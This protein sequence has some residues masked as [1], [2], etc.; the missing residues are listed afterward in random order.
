MRYSFASDV[1]VY[2]SVSV[3][4]LTFFVSQV[5]KRPAM[6]GY[7]SVPVIDYL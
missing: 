3:G 1:Q 6:N 5:D 7:S 4:T 2:E